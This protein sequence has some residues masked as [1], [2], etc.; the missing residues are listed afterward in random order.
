LT[1]LFSLV[2]IFM[3]LIKEAAGY[4]EL[5]IRPCFGDGSGALAVDYP[6]EPLSSKEMSSRKM[7]VYE[8]EKLISIKL[9][10][11]SAND[12]ILMNLAVKF[13]PNDEVVVTFYA[14]H[15]V[16]TVYKYLATRFK[17]K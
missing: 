9:I 14:P 8:L 15:Q 6:K 12:I 5:P 10:D 3:F 1:S 4:N 11:N 17:K 13:S 2:H 16:E 7:I